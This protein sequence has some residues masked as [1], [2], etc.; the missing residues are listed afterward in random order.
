MSD[1]NLFCAI[2]DEKGHC[3]SMHEFYIGTHVQGVGQVVLPV[4]RAEIQVCDGCSKKIRCILPN[5]IKN[6]HM[7]EEE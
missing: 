2:C 4:P 7:G 6:Y 3:F 1:R 5:A